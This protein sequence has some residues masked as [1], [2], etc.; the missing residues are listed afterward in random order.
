MTDRGRRQLFRAVRRSG[1]RPRVA[2]RFG[3]TQGNRL[4]QNT[5]VFQACP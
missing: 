4:W 5:G 1:E 2:N 3:L